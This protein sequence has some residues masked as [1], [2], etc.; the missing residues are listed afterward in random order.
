VSRRMNSSPV[1]IDPALDD[2]RVRATKDAVS[3]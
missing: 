2:A 1:L 3:V